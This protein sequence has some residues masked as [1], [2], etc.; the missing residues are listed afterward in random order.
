MCFELKLGRFF[1]GCGVPVIVIAG[2]APPMGS[3]RTPAL[4]SYPGAVGYQRGD[5]DLIERL[6]EQVGF[7]R[8]SAVAYDEG[9]H[10]EARRL[11]TTVRILCHDTGRSRALLQQL[12]LLE[13]LRFVDTIPDV[14]A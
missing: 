14:A 7:L 6:Q 13:E 10:S 8:R 9:E 3:V 12:G 1:E 2:V 11:A 5:T 4:R